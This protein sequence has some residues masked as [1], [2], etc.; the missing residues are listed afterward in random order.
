MVPASKTDTVRSRLLLPTSVFER[1]IRA[2]LLACML[3]I[4]PVRI[5]HV[6]RKGELVKACQPKQFEVMQPSI[7]STFLLVHQALVSPSLTTP[8]IKV[9]NKNF[10]RFL[11]L[12]L[13]EQTNLTLSP[14]YG[15]DLIID[16]DS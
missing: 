4:V 1:P 7:Y 13:L 10:H 16:L 12:R 8:A 11:S 15:Y 9:I 6:S 5:I 2:R 14:S 3:T